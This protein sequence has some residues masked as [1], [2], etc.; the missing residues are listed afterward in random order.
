[1]QLSEH[2]ARNRE[3]W[4]RDAPGW[5]DGTDF[6]QPHGER[7][8]LR[9]WAQRWRCEEVWVARRRNAE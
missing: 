3:Q 9:G 6:A 4:N 5:P 2:A 8:A 1:M 7:I